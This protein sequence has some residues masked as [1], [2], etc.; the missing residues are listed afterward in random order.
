M[1]HV[2]LLLINIILLTS[3]LQEIF[4]STT[5]SDNIVSNNSL[6]YDIYLFFILANLSVF[7]TLF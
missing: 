1:K 4:I 5:T 2:Q 7:V 6:H 3:K